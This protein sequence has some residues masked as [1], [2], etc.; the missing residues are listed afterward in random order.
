MKKITLANQMD[1]FTKHKWKVG[2]RF[3]YSFSTLIMQ[4][5]RAIATAAKIHIKY[6]E[7]TTCEIT[8]IN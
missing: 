4:D 3:K 5:V 2:D 6:I 8:Q 7:G 1:F